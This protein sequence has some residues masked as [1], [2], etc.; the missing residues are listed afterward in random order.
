MNRPSSGPNGKNNLVKAPEKQPCPQKPPQGRREGFIP[1]IAA[2]PGH[3]AAALEVLFRVTAVTAGRYN[4][5]MNRQLLP[6][7]S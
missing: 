4:P 7:P 1:A 3:A 5:L 6:L 2:F